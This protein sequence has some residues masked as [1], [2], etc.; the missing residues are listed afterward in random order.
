MFRGSTRL[1]MDLYDHPDEVKATLRE[2]T[3]A[4]K[5]IYGHRF[6]IVHADEEGCAG[7]NV[8]APG[9]YSVLGCDFSVNISAEQYRE[10]V[11]PEIAEGAR[12][13]DYS[14]YHLDGPNATHHLPA[15]FEIED[16]NGIQFTIGA[17]HAYLPD[18]HWIPL[19]KRIQDAG[20]L[21]R[22][23]A[24]YDGVESLLSELDPRGIMIVT[25]APSIEAAEALLRNV[26]RWSCRGVHVMPRLGT[27][28]RD[29]PGAHG[30]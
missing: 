7:Q 25:Y 24:R 21:V 12:Y 1:C 23:D 16:L 5:W 10:F 6:E 17:A 30:D 29:D 18:A 9:R 14:F 2:L 20:K 11:M 13:L 27:Q 3:N 28:S 26:D 4:W 19:Y 8:W 22:I 15:L